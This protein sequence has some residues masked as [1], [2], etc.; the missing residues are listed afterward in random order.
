ME[1]FRSVFVSREFCFSEKIIIFVVGRSPKSNLICVEY[2]ME[3]C[4]GAILCEKARK[5]QLKQI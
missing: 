5:T 2:G 4:Q 1:T 3:I